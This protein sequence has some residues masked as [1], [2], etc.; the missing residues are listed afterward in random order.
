[1]PSTPQRI[2]SV[3]PDR[4]KPAPRQKTENINIEK[5]NMLFLP[6][7]SAMLPKNSSRE[8]AVKLQIMLSVNSISKNKVSTYLDAAFIQVISALVMPKSLP[9]K[10]DITVIL[11]VK[12]LDIAIA[13]VTDKT[14]KH[15]CSV[16]LKHSGRALGSL[17]LIGGA[18]AWPSSGPF[19]GSAAMLYRWTL[20]MF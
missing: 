2:S 6:N 7:K 8:P 1:M 14:N 4:E 10:L 13:M 20:S 16:D 17:L 5:M 11:P 18:N 3:I 15:S 19:S 12:K 9:T